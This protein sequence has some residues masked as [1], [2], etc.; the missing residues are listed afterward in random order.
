MCTQDSVYIYRR[1][2]THANGN[3]PK[4]KAWHDKNKIKAKSNAT[5]NTHTHTH[6]YQLAKTREA[7]TKD[8]MRA[9]RKLTHAHHEKAI[10]NN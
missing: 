6:T 10:K 9:M 2:I 5:V 4:T 3:E 1:I 8:K 7:T